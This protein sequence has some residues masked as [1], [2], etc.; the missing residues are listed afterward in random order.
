MLDVLN[1]WKQE[2]GAEV[3]S[4]FQEEV[5]R[6]VMRRRDA[7]VVMPRG[8]DRALCFQVPA[9]L[10]KGLVVVISPRCRERMVNRKL[11]YVRPKR[12]GRALEWLQ[13]RE[14]GLFV[15][16]EAQCMGEWRKDYVRE[17]AGL[18]CL[19]RLFPGVPIVAMTAE[20]GNMMRNFLSS[21]LW[22]R[23]W[24]VFEDIS[25]EGESHM[26]RQKRLHKNAYAKWSRED[27][28]TL[29]A[30]YE[31]GGTMKVLATFFSRNEGAIRSRL[32]KLKNR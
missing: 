15:V 26:A 28:R 10:M 8:E 20:P 18:G 2:A 6:H 22:L 21:Q 13:G 17:Y 25:G 31:A 24:A 16:D 7:V 3:M 1:I 19:R 11:F 23:G 30:M 32:N 5:I 12:L 4:P 14:V 9:M 27:D 29:L